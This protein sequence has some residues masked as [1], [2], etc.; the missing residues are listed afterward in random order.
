MRLLSLYYHYHVFWDLIYYRTS[1][2]L[3]AGTNIAD[4]EDF[5]VSNNLL[6]LDSLSFYYSAPANMDGAW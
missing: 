2:P 1:Q 6:P 5:I 4:L 3:G